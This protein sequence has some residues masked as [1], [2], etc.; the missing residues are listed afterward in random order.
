M[1]NSSILYTFLL[2]SSQ[3]GTIHCANNIPKFC[4][5]SS[6]P[7]ESDSECESTCTYPYDWTASQNPDHSKRLKVFILMGQSNMM[8]FGQI[9]PA[10][11][12]GTLLYEINQGKYSHLVKS[13][14]STGHVEWSS[15]RDVR[16]V[17]RNTV[18]DGNAD[19]QVRWNGEKHSYIGPEIQFGH[20]VGHIY[21]NP[22]LLI[23]VGT[24]GRALGWDFLPRGSERYT[25]G[26]KSYPGHH[27]CPQI[28]KINSYEG[29]DQ[30]C[31]A[32]SISDSGWR[33]CHLHWTSK[34]QC[35]ACG[36][37]MKSYA[38][39]QYD[40]DLENVKDTL[41]NIEQYYPEYQG[42]GFDIEGFVFW[43]GFNDSLFDAYVMKYKGK[44][45]P[46]V[47]ITS[48]SN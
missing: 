30:E 42:Q 37:G 29:S 44:R 45:F 31:G 47:F 8:G 40:L 39:Y 9:E 23:K 35:L 16:I 38:G 33:N 36:E 11:R 48:S 26:T 13:M 1:K 28:S 22:V 19:L 32:C 10:D 24:G 6:I 27:E 43:Q 34:E 20:V 18:I 2:L 15:R 5:G 7:C 25:Y 3:L 4:Q 41:S 14:N 12:Q 17:H 46:V 21:E